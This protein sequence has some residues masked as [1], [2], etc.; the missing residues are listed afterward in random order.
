MNQPALELKG[1]GRFVISFSHFVPGSMFC[2]GSPPE[3]YP[4]LCCDEV[5]DQAC[6]KNRPPIFLPVNEVCAY[7]ILQV[8]CIGSKVHVFGHSH[9]NV[10]IRTRGVRF[11]QNGQ[12]Y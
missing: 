12:I 3:L 7:M 11:V 6:L 10:D 9:N 4:I 5:A 1:S 2:Q 8:Y